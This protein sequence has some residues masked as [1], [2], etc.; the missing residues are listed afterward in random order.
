MELKGMVGLH[1]R[2]MM[3]NQSSISLAIVH[4]PWL[5]RR[6]FRFLF[7][8]AAQPDTHE[9]STASAFLSRCRAMVAELQ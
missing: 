6:G 8:L 9:A 4:D 2:A 3:L 1:E 5:H 7:Q